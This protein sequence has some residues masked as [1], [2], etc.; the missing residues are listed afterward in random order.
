M[1]CGEMGWDMYNSWCG[2]PGHA[3]VLLW[4]EDSG[5]GWDGDNSSELSKH[6][7]IRAA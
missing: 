1:V 6:G 4:D 7:D 3:G 2:I 5:V